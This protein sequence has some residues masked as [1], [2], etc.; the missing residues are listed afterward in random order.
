MVHTITNITDKQLFIEANN[1]NL[2]L[3]DALTGSVILNN[4]C[5]I[6][7]I[8]KPVIASEPIT[9]TA[10]GTGLIIEGDLVVYGT[11]IIVN[12]EKVYNNETITNDLTVNGN[13]YLGNQSIDRTII[14]GKLG[15]ATQSLTDTVNVSGIISSTSGGFRF[16]DGTVQTSAGT[17]LS[18]FNLEGFYNIA[19]N[20]IFERWSGYT[21][22]I[23]NPVNGTTIANSWTSTKSASATYTKDV[24]SLF[25]GTNSMQIYKTS[26]GGSAYVSQVIDTSATKKYIPVSGTKVFYASCLTKADMVSGAA[27]QIYDGT[28]TTSVS[29]LT[30]NAVERLSAFVTLSSSATTVKIMLVNNSST[31]NKNC[32]FGEVSFYEGVLAKPWTANAVDEAGY[33]V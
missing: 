31:I 14:T 24:T 32:Y 15:V 3:N 33:Y 23:V 25:R 27:L 29:N 5:D 9:I 12:N 13:T 1:I 28:N 8:Y 6:V 30:I 21:I 7:N 10:A 19:Q 18:S 16:P 20:S 22:P 26:T 11:S 4:G 17:A 2:T